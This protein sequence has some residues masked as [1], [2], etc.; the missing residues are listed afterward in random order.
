MSHVITKCSNTAKG[1]QVPVI[2]LTSITT[3]SITTEDYT[4]TQQLKTKSH[5]ISRHT[6]ITLTGLLWLRDIHLVG[7]VCDKQ[8][9]A[10]VCYKLLTHRAENIWVQLNTQTS[11]KRSNSGLVLHTSGQMAPDIGTTCCRPD[12]MAALWTCRFFRI[13][14]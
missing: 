12:A 6:G 3:R 10:K 8:K 14:F 13:K 9:E 2:H 4:H 7:D 5:L 11:N 1:K